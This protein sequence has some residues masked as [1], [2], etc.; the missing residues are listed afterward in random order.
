MRSAS[1]IYLLDDADQKFF[2]EG[3]CRLLRAVEETGSLR[4]AALSMEMAYSK[5]NKL[6][7]TAESA[8]GFPLLTRAVG[9][10]DGGGS[11]LTEEAAEW[12]ARFE[13]YRNACLAANQRLFEEYFPAQ[14]GEPRFGCVIMASGFGRRFGGNK[15][16]TDFFGR[17]LI[18]WILDATEGL[19]AH[20]VVVTRYEEVRALCAARGVCAVVHDLPQRSDTVRL[21]VEALPQD[22]AGCLFCT[23][24][25]PLVARRSIEAILAQAV[26]EPRCIHRLAFGETVGSPV[27]FPADDFEELRHLPAGKGGN[28][29]LRREPERVRLVQAEREEELADV[30]CPQDLEKLEELLKR[31]TI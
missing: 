22:L 1:R 4:A 19:F 14:G 13:A 8:L 28:V 31:R 29:I 17:P 24:D 15:L 21:G 10:R 23:G 27:L 6:I 26:R 25:Q 30:D 16:L 9:G 2:G 11:R 12:L 7:K 20:R 3:P 5:A 18:E